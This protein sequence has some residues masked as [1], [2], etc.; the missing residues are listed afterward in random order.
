VTVRAREFWVF[1]KSLRLWN[2]AENTVAVVE[3]RMNDRSGVMV[4]AVLNLR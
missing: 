3:F 2:T 1:L 4:L